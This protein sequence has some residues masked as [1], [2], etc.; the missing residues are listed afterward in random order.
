MNYLD[1]IDTNTPGRRCDVTPLF[2]NPQAFAQLLA[3][4]WQ[5]F[6]SREVKYIAGLDALGFIL[7]AALAQWVGLGFIPVRKGGKL[8][9]PSDE[10]SFMDYS[11]QEKSLALRQGAVRPG[12]RIVLVDEWIETG[13]QIDA[14][15]QLVE[16]QGGR[17][18]GIATI[19]MDDCPRTRQ[20]REKYICQVLMVPG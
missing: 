10:I 20:I 17:I 7:G 14:A 4:L 5:P 6:A 19:A 8:P 1:L 3:D 2:A 16:G 9:V 11:G 12:E 18:V 13:A 15:I